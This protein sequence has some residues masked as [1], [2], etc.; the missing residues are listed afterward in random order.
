VAQSIEPIIREVKPHIKPRGAYSLYRVEA[1]SPR[2]I[3][4]GG[5]VLEGDIGDFLGGV[6]RVAV[7]LV[8]VGDDITRLAGEAWD[9]GDALTGWAYDALGSWAAEAAADAMTKHL[10]LQLKAGEALT[11]RFSPGYCGMYLEQQRTLFQLVRAADVGVE[12]LP[13]FLMKPLKSIS[14]VIGMGPREALKDGQTPCE[15]CVRAGCP[16]RR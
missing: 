13:S 14:G 8:T 15:S 7:F 11:L 2:S 5:T 3:T 10:G 16:M 6:E 9:R 4:L 1:R 12:L